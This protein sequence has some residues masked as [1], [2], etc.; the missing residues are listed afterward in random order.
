VYDLKGT[1]ADL[2]STLGVEAQFA[3]STDT[4]DYVAYALDV[5]TSN[6][7]LGTLACI[8]PD[9]AAHYDLNAPVL[10]AELNWEAVVRAMDAQSGY[11]P[12]PRVPVVERDLAV[13]VDATA[14]VGPLLDTAQEAGAPLVQHVEL[15]DLYKGEGIPEKKQSV[16]LSM[17][18]AADHTLT[19]SEI[20]RCMTQ[21]QTALSRQHGA[22]LRQQ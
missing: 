14:P 8:H 6:T 15:F 12:A 18:L 2:L 9:T 10:V 19:D 21:V 16:A 7:A 17:R 22:T 4:P 5:A 13:L 11:T 3:P 1:V 20:D